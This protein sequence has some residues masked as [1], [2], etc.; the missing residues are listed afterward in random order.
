MLIFLGLGGGGEIWKD[1]QNRNR[2]RLCLD[3]LVVF[4]C[5]IS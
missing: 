5:I 2:F 1:M 3:R 4:G